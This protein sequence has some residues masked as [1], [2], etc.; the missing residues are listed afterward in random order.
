MKKMVLILL[1]LVLISSVSAFDFDNVKS[2]NEDS[3]TVTI[4]NT[5]GLSKISELKLLTP[6]RVF[7]L[8]G[9]DR[10]IAEIEIVSY[11]GSYENAFKRLDF[12]DK[13][14]NMKQIDKEFKYKYRKVSGQIEVDDYK[15]TCEELVNSSVRCYS[16][17]VG[18]HYED[19]YEWIEFNEFN[20][21]SPGKNV[22]GIFT[23]VKTTDYVEWIP[24]FF[25]VE[26][27]EWAAFIG[28]EIIEGYFVGSDGS[29]GITPDINGSQT[30][31]IG[32]IGTNTNFDLVGVQIE[33]YQTSGASDVRVCIFDTNGTTPRNQLVCND[34]I[35]E[36]QFGAALGSAINIS[37]E[38]TVGYV[39]QPDTQYALVVSDDSEA[40]IEWR[41]DLS[42]A[43]YVGGLAWTTAL[44]EEWK[45]I[46]TCD[47]DFMFEIYGTLNPTPVVTVDSPKNVSYIVNN[48]NINASSNKPVD[49]WY[50]N[51]GSA[52]RTFTPNV[53]VGWEQGQ[54]T[55]NVWANST[56][57]GSWGNRSVTFFI[58]R[59]LVNNLNFSNTTIE[60]GTETFTINFSILPTE[61]VQ[62]VFLNWNNTRFEGT[63]DLESGVTYTGTTTIDIPELTAS[64]SID[65]LWEIIFQ[66]GSQNSTTNSQTVAALGVDNCSVNTYLILN[67]TLRDEDTQVILNG[68]TYN[69]TMEIDLDLFPIGSSTSIVNFSATYNATN[70]ALVCLSSNINDTVYRL[71]SVIRY[72]A[73]EGDYISE[74]H[75]IQSFIL[76]NKTAP[77]VVDLYDLL[78][79]RSTEFLITFK[80]STFLPVE[81][82]LVDITR[83][84]IGEGVFKSVEVPKTDKKG[85]AIGHF[86]LS[87]QKYTIIIKKDGII[88][89]TFDNVAVVCED[90]IISNC[91]IN[92]N[93]FTSSIQTED[94][95]TEAGLDYILS[96]NELTRIITVIFTTMSGG[97]STVSLNTT[98]YDRFGNTTICSDQLTT[99]SGTLTCLIPE[100]F[101]NITVISKLFNNGELVTMNTFTID[102]P[103]LF[104]ADGIILGLI[105]L[106]TLPLMAITSTVGVAIF[107]IVGLIAVS[108][109]QLF[110]A[111]SIL[112]P[113][114]AI[115]WIII[116]GVIIIFKIRNRSSG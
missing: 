40:N 65:F 23:D 33:A 34:S 106:I 56:A 115:L 55:L 19:T 3:K 63:F 78:T 71:D 52:N 5:F 35:D 101:G 99:S 70:P 80:D 77:L 83:S 108:L 75:H 15:W 50:W 114:A 44:G 90:R 89:A 11:V 6:Q 30:F 87:E 39:F 13:W 107:A 92:L 73:G 105:L 94:F 22:I 38:G 27:D 98:Q 61:S 66:T 41:I 47:D 42:A 58:S 36:T 113:G 20:D 88:L 10:K 7:A 76:T 95:L 57:D 32:T 93:Q 17:N 9:S 96:F 37:F 53:S 104:G 111:G 79:S 112:G 14:F 103:D 86:V 62:T 72:Q 97:T 46:T 67:Y 21:L 81:N 84:Y 31:T 1:I 110:D 59:M 48:I 85:Q 54:H 102:D 116:A 64:A 28:S 74:L 109:L 51:N 91:R 100:S 69:T 2:Y 26:I 4:K 24:T 8:S 18:F 82:A 12:Y 25:G 16:K 45:C 49:P 60:G 43:T 29:H 68:A